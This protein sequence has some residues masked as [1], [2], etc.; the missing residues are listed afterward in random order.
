MSGR[1][2]R[3]RS[4]MQ[5]VVHEMQCED[6][7]FMAASIAYHAFVSMLPILLLLTLGVSMFE[8]ERFVATILEVTGVFLPET[9]QQIVADTIRNATGDMGL[10]VVSIGVLLWGTSKIFRAMDAAFA[11][12]YDT[13]RNLSLLD[14]FRDA[15]VVVLALAAAAA[16]AILLG[17]VVTVPDGMPFSWVL[18]GLV[19]ILGLI[20]AFFPLYY[21]FPDIDVSVREVL[22]GVLVAAIGW[23][24]LE[25]FF[26]LYASVSNKPDIYGLIGSLLLLVIWFYSGGLVLLAGA[27][28][29]ATLAGRAGDPMTRRRD[30]RQFG[31]Q[32]T[33]TESFEGCLDKLVAKASDANIPEGD[34]QRA[35]R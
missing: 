8:S 12:I 11:Q 29:N 2:E 22:P 27:A 18:D 16:V 5:A 4:G 26:H 35:L 17:S 25:W 9:S 19:V 31:R 34:I 20:V 23:A 7:T 32:V 6:I 30:K 33:D 13:K 15:L 28:V 1:F 3:A 24:G 14:Q 10:S 21:V